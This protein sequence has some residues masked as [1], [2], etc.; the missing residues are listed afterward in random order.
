M[1]S[2]E[3]LRIIDQRTEALNARDWDRF[4]GLH[5]DS[6]VY[7]PGLGPSLRGRADLLGF[8]QALVKASPDFRLRK[9]HAF[10]DS[11]WVR[12][13]YTG[14]GTLEGN[15]EGPGGM[16][17]PATNKPFRLRDCTVFRVEGG[18]IAE[19]RVYFDPLGIMA[20]LGL[21]P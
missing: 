9:E 2:E 8:F 4:L 19:V 3:T 17:I 15:L 20:Q 1:S 12:A 14:S 11:G 18:K 5:A 16:T 21:G 13:E 7:T 10:G 6:V